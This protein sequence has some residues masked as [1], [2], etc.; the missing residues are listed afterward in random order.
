MNSIC[1]ELKH[2]VTG[3]ECKHEEALTGRTA[4]RERSNSRLLGRNA[5]R[6]TK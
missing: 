3:Q 4:C 5:S 1:I 6:R 2:H